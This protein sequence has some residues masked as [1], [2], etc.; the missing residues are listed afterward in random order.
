LLTYR[1][2]LIAQ[3][4]ASSPSDDYYDA[5]VKVLSEMISTTSKKKSS[6]RHVC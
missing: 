3:I 4:E 5:K 1:A 6:R 2:K